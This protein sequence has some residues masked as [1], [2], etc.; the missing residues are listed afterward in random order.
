MLVIHTVYLEDHYDFIVILGNKEIKCIIIISS[1]ISII[2]IIKNMPK[3]AIAEYV[4]YHFLNLSSEVSVALSTPQCSVVT[5]RFPEDV[6]S[7]NL[8]VG[9]HRAADLEVLPVKGHGHLTW[10]VK[11]RFV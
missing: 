11:L 5:S 1:I 3:E 10:A 8:R 9:S 4:S 6:E 7:F 2:I